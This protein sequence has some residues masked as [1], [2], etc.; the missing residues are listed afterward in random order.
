MIDAKDQGK[1]DS[2][3]QT[4]QSQIIVLEKFSSTAQR[5]AQ[6]KQDAMNHEATAT[7][8]EVGTTKIIVIAFTIIILIIG[9]VV[10]I[11]I[12]NTIS[13][14][15]QQLHAIAVRIATG[16]LTHTQ[17]V[18]VRNRDEIGELAASFNQMSNNLRQLILAAGSNAEQVAASSQQLSASADQTG[19][20]TE[21]VTEI[22]E[23]LAEGTESQVERVAAS[24]ELVHRMDADAQNISASAAAVADA[25]MLTASVAAEGGSAVRTAIAQMSAVQCSVNEVSQVVSELGDR[26]R[27]IGDIMAIITDIATQTNLLSLNAAIEAARAGE[28]GRGFAVVAGEVRKLAE[29]TTQSGRRVSEVINAIQTEIDRITAKVSQG[30]Q[31]ALAGIHAVNTAGQSFSQIEAAI[32]DVTLQIREVSDSSHHMSSETH[33]LVDA[34]ETINR[35]AIEMA[36]GTHSVSA[37]AEEQLASV[38]EIAAASKELSV[39]A[40]Q[41]QENIDKFKV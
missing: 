33:K 28:H 4:A 19:Q 7:F 32:Q 38:Q 36:E 30:E 11:L 17:Q 23:Q 12:S 27:E 39:L 18:V 21:H 20:A 5:F 16:D 37:S 15:I 22:T 2:F 6:L 9:I 1:T 24:V 41:L 25:V 29:Q 34:F 8:E 26:S 3:L 13:R 14:P 35:T 40:Q 10:S 31:E